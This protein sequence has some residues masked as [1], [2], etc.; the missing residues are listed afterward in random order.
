MESNI[1][2]MGRKEM[3]SRHRLDN[4]NEALPDEIREA[5]VLCSAL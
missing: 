5:F 4:M 2:R 3:D 1:I